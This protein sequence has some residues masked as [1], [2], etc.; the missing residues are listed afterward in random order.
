MKAN[1]ISIAEC[2][3]I[4]NTTRRRKSFTDEEIKIIRDFLCL[5]AEIECPD[6]KSK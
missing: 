4:F 1:S 5:M 6:F 2:R 3:K